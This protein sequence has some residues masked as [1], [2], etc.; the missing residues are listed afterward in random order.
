MNG[1][2]S[3]RG[4]I[5]A[6]STHLHGYARSRATDPLPPSIQPSAAQT[7]Y[8]VAADLQGSGDEVDGDTVV[9]LPAPFQCLATMLTSGSE[10]AGGMAQSWLLQLLLVHAET[11]MAGEIL[12]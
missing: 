2:S 8:D 6:L 7:L 10:W 1:L 11:V 5:N 12:P 3:S 9:P 4:F